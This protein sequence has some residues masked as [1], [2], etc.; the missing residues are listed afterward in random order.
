MGAEP[1]AGE[2]T[3]SFGEEDRRH[4]RR[5]IALARR[6]WGRVAPNPLVGAVVVRDGRVVGEGWHR[7]FGAD[8]A[9]VVA[10]REAGS[11]A[12]GGIL[13]TSLEPCAHHGK[14]PPC[15]DAVLASGIRRV[16]VAARDPHRMASGGLERLREAGISV[17]LGAE[18]ER[19]VRANAAFLWSEARDLPFA[20]LKLGLTLDG[21]IAERPG[22]R[23]RVTGARAWREVHRLRAGHDA[24]LIGRRTAAVDDPRLTVRGRPP[25][26]R[27]PVRVVLDPHL[28]LPRDS[29]LARTAPQV[30]T[31]VLSAPEAPGG[32]RRALEAA[33]VRVLEVPLA[34]EHR[35]DL[36]EAWRL[37]R[38]EGIGSVLVEGGG[39]V[40]SSLLRDGLLQRMHLIYAPRAFGKAGVPAFPDLEGA[41]EIWRAWRPARSRRLG[42]DTLLVL[43]HSAVGGLARRL[44]RGEE[45][46][47]RTAPVPAGADPREPEGGP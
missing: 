3:A 34:G 41:P 22:A 33:G 38:G 26:R 2:R 36:P 44:T 40:T 11:A 9:E 24:V 35:L 30:P 21:R 20:V 4:M 7:A 13:Y 15:V 6:G 17:S 8:H 42:R 1:E 46:E 27:P 39:R 25:P 12:R 5:A 16:V 14:T 37:L 29:T 28:G 10:L 23:S 31:W 32:A 43:E 19:A 18:G 45:R 47:G